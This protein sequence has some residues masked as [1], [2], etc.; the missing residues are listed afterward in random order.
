DV[1]VGNHGEEPA[2]YRNLGGG[3]F[4]DVHAAA[5]VTPRGD[6]H[7]AG[8]GDENGDGQPD[9]YVGFGAG[10]GHAQKANQLYRNAGGGHF[11]ERGASAGATDPAG[12]ARTVAWV[13]YDRDG[14]LDLFVGNFASPNVLLHNEGDGA[15]ADRAALAGLARPPAWRAVWTDYDRD[16]W[17]DVLLAA[18]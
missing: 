4:E 10:R 17:P 7:G 6:V 9:L 5:G 15:F 3:R 18:T 13:D 16:G 12:R 1:F 2:L 14:K 11:T 8:W